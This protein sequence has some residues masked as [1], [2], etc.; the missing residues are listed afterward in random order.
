MVN[1]H[2]RVPW[3][4]STICY[5]T[6]ATYLKKIILSFQDCWPDLSITPYKTEHAHEQNSEIEKKRQKSEKSLTDFQEPFSGRTSDH[7]ASE[8]SSEK[9][10]SK[11]SAHSFVADYEEEHERALE[12]QK[13]ISSCEKLGETE[14]SQT[15]QFSQENIKG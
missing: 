1:K 4:P 15:T 14:L 3:I 12:N 5:K 13:L 8:N 11:K 7:Q 10:N 2:K 9:T 6:A